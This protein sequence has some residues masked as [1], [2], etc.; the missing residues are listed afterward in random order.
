[1]ANESITDPNILAIMAKLNQTE[2]TFQ[3][4]EK[5]EEKKVKENRPPQTLAEFLKAEKIVCKNISD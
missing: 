1:M 2:E 5:E 3:R 4:Q